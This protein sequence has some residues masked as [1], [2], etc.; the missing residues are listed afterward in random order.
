MSDWDETMQ[1]ALTEVMNMAVG[2]ASEVLSTMVN[3]EVVLT[4]PQLEFGDFISLYRKIQGRED[5]SLVAIHEDFSGSFSG[6]AFLIF[7]EQQSLSLVAAILGTDDVS[8]NLS[9]VAREALMEIGNIILN[10]CLGTI[11]NLLGYSVETSLPLFE[12]WRL[13]EH[14][15]REKQGIFVHIDFQMEQTGTTGYLVI[16]MSQSSLDTLHS[17]ISKLVESYG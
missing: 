7:P 1:D 16:F 9:E 8:E 10:S 12:N 15:D 14:Q 5:D 6:E 13:Q 17:G 4:V 3:E 11:C 2:G